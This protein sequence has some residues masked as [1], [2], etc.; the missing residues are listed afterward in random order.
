MDDIN[1]DNFYIKTSIIIVVSTLIGIL[2]LHFFELL[3]ILFPVLFVANAIKDGFGES[4]TNMLVTLVILAVAESVAISVMLAIVFI[5]FTLVLSYLIKNRKGNFKIIGISAVT[6]F[7]SLLIIM[8]IA[9]LLG[10]DVPAY[11]ETTVQGVMDNQIEVFESMDFTNVEIMELKDQL[12]SSYKNL[13]VRIPSAILMVSVVIS[14]INYLLSGI[15][16]GKFGIRIVNLPK[17]SH[18]R[19]PSNVIVGSLLMFLV[20]YISGQMG[21]GYYKAVFVNIAAL[22]AMGLFVQGFSTVSYLLN[23][24]KF[25]ILLKGIIYI[26]IFLNGAFTSLVS[27]VGLADLVFDFRKLRKK[28]KK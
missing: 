26:M 4:I 19:L 2:G 12:E 10:V 1:I 7:A 16:L 13:L 8:I 27:I 25:N 14:Y 20:T 15:I 6:F 24:F 23:K 17:L 3:L 22:I 11:L 21:F 5:P 28:E 9:S 18:I